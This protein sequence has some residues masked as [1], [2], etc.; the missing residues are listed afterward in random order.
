L[1]TRLTC[2]VFLVY[3]DVLRARGGKNGVAVPDALHEVGHQ[4]HVK[5][6]LRELLLESFHARQ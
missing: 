5:I 4:V 1:V 3:K 2:K 6:H